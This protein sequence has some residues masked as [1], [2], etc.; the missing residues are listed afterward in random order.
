MYQFGVQK[1]SKNPPGVWPDPPPP[2]G[3]LPPGHQ[4]GKSVL[5]APTSGHNFPKTAGPRS[6]P[7]S[8][9]KMPPWAAATSRTT[10]EAEGGKGGSILSCRGTTQPPGPCLPYRPRRTA[11]KTRATTHPTNPGPTNTLN[12]CP[13][14]KKRKPF[15]LSIWIEMYVAK[16]AKKCTI[17]WRTTHVAMKTLQ[18]PWGLFLSKNASPHHPQTK[19]SPLQPEGSKSGGGDKN[20]TGPSC[21]A[22]D[23]W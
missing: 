21:F 22:C 10:A 14:K 2:V 12:P 6:C 8:T 19:Q 7:R 13:S 18:S 11:R 16:T 17:L 9:E 4:L 5:T 20:M 23:V 1:W 3:D 15:K